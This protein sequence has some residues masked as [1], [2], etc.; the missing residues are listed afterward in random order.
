MKKYLIPFSNFL[1]K[2]GEIQSKKYFSIVYQRMEEKN[3]FEEIL[4]KVI[5]ETNPY[6]KHKTFNNFSISK[7]YF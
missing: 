2:N 5:R 7:L 6:C 3:S 1:K 4:S